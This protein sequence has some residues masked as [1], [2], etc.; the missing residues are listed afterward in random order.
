MSMSRSPFDPYSFRGK[1]PFVPYDYRPEPQEDSVAA[2]AKRITE[3]AAETR[4][5][6]RRAL[7]PTIERIVRDQRIEM[8]PEH[9]DLGER[10]TEAET[11]LRG[12]QKYLSIP[13]DK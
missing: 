11:M 4:E 10:A 2:E 9:Q 3:D 8:A 7:D 13:E 5:L 6:G 12:I 1:E